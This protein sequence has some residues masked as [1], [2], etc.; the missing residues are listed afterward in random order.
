MKELKST[1]AVSTEK[2]IIKNS[3]S[4]KTLLS[5]PVDPASKTSR[6]RLS[7]SPREELSPG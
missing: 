5:K 7:K 4:K 2:A 3:N 1:L 6:Y